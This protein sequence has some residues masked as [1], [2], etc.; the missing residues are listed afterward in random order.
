MEIKMR[1]NLYKW[2]YKTDLIWRYDEMY[3]TRPNHDKTDISLQATAE[4]EKCWN[5]E[6]FSSFVCHDTIGYIYN[7]VI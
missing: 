4:L 5:N 6:V 3:T 1:W 2:H 7:V